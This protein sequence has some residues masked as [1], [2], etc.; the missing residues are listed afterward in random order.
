MLRK[1]TSGILGALLALSNVFAYQ[2]GQPFQIDGG[3]GE[4]TLIS[5]FFVVSVILAFMNVGD[6]LNLFGSVML[7]VLGFIIML[8]FQVVLGILI[9]ALGFTSLL[10][11]K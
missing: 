7:F 2:A 10:S 9:F 1:I 5:V 3:T 8:N 6:T 11:V 4:L